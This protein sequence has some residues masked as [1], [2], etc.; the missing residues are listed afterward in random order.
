MNLVSDKA[1]VEGVVGGGDLGNFC[2]TEEMETP[3][4][5]KTDLTEG[6]KEMTLRDEKERLDL[7][8]CQPRTWEKKSGIEIEGIR[9]KCDK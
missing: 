7:V 5:K 3:S 4:T 9:E 8:R 1:L 6:T 2:K